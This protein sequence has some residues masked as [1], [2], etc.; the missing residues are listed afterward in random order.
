MRG[1]R[2]ARHGYCSEPFGAAAPR[3][4]HHSG[5]TANMNTAHAFPRQRADIALPG[6]RLAVSRRRG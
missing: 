3:S 4:G 2:P 6:A 5:R 1:R